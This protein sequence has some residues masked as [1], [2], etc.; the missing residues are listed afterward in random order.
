MNEIGCPGNENPGYFVSNLLTMN[1]REKGILVTGILGGLV[2]Y[3]YAEVARS[4]P[5]SGAEVFG[6][7]DI[8]ADLP[9]LVRRM[10]FF[11]SEPDNQECCVALSLMLRECE[12][13]AQMSRDLEAFPES[14]W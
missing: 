9:E 5:G 10:D 12:G 8:D 2:A 3:G 11:Y 14:D 13:G 4:A 7:I 1:P 6:R